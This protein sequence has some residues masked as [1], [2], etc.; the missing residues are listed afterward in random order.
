MTSYQMNNIHLKNIW[1]S[2]QQ[3]IDVWMNS[4]QCSSLPIT[5]NTSK[6]SGAYLWRIFNKQGSAEIKPLNF[7]HKENDLAYLSMCTSPSKCG[8]MCRWQWVQMFWRAF[9]ASLATVGFWRPTSSLRMGQGLV[10]F[11]FYYLICGSV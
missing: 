2:N 1:A 9:A 6:V 11:S 8:H 5:Q 10:S 7:L 4:P 3:N